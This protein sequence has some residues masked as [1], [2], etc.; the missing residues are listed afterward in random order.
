MKKSVNFWII[1]FAILLFSVRW[2]N[3]F[4]NFYE[5]IDSKII[6]ESVSDG[7][8]Y[9]SQLKALANFNLN[10]SFD[11]NVVNLGTVSVP[12]GALILHLILYL[13][14]GSLSFI[15]SEFFFIFLF[16]I[17]F[18]KIFRLLS[19]NRIQSIALSLVLF[20]IP[21]FLQFLSLENVTYLSVINNE[22]F[23]LRFPRPLVSNIYFFSFILFLTSDKI[24][25]GI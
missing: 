9:F 5:T 18:Y 11:P 16:L 13:V 10:Y 19:F 15:I 24:C 25:L 7:Y 14:I 22:F 21:D 20:T 4:S 1:I 12:T 8:Y 3:S 2:F 23:S 6:F 17:I